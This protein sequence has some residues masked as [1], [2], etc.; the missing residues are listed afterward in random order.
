[1]KKI[2]L[3]AIVGAMLMFALAACSSQPAS[4][5][6][7]SSAS[8][9]SA[10][11]SAASESAASES[12]SAS[13]ASESAASESA[14]ASAASESAASELAATPT[15][16]ELNTL[17]VDKDAKT[18]SIW[19]Q[20][21][22]KYLTEPTHHFECNKDGKNGEKAVMRAWVKPAELYDALISLG[23]KPGDNLTVGDDAKGKFIE[24]DKIEVTLDWNGSNGPVAM[25][26]C[27][28]QLDGSAY[29]TDMR[30]GGNIDASNEMQTGCLSCTFSCPVG[31]ISNAK[32]GY[33]T[34][35]VI[36]N[37]DV[38]PPDGTYVLVT[39]KLV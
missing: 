8:A 10:S 27:L 29:E 7:A 31:I 1:M 21:N 13:A 14:S 23:A 12:A 34:E 15:E 26:D 38:L 39:Y 35:D 28:K 6:S 33:S 36:G 9:S 4:S 11:A 25:A 3:A 24:G 17:I 2:V 32:Y 20:I 22:G 18:I 16:A 5:A 19:G 30:F 37:S